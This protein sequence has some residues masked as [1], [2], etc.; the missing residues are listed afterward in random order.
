MEAGRPGSREPEML[1]DERP[2]G[3]S[4]ELIRR[5]VHAFY[6]KVREDL[7]LGPIFES[8]LRDR[9]DAHLAT[10]IDFWSS[11]ALRSG[12]YAGKPHAAHHG[13]NLEHAHF[14]RWLDL[15][16]ETV[17]TLCERDVAAFFV[18]RAHRIADSL[19]VG[20]N[21]GPK[22]LHFPARPARDTFSGD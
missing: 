20:L 2:A 21:I 14:L 19:Q 18:D 3:L 12:R 13:L 8:K 7:V 1:I 15:F 16:E 6:G 9:W 17:S 22:A 5:I 4:E 11:V 10:M